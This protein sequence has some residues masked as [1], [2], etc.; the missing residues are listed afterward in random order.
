MKYTINNTNPQNSSFLEEEYLPIKVKL[1][2]CELNK[3]I[4]LY[5]SD[6]DLA[7]FSID[8]NLNSITKFVLTLCNHYSFVD[9]KLCPATNS[10]CEIKLFYPSKI[11][12]YFFLVTVYK[13][14]VSINCSNT[15]TVEFIRTGNLIIGFDSQD[16]I[17]EIQIC[18][19]TTQNIQ[20]IKNELHQ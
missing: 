12:C 4:G 16:D 11:E 6:T 3:H 8:Y 19:L 14:G 2:D 5:Y 20:F 15:E 13:D 7:E 17:S 18:N 9:E 10:N 1:Y